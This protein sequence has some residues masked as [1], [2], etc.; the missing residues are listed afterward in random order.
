M[1]YEFTEKNNSKEANNF[2]KH[3]SFNT[4]TNN[5]KIYPKNHPKT[6][7]NSI[8][9]TI[10]NTSDNN[11]INSDKRHSNSN[12]NEINFKLTRHH[13]YNSK[14]GRSFSFKL[15]ENKLTK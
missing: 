4:I 10:S 8:C 13:H 11:N 2:I 1:N 12:N 7:T 5:T 14:L 3:S 9:L 15:N 6:Y